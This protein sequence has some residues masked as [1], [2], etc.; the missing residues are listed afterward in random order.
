M[1]FFI[2][3]S[4][5]GLKRFESESKL[6]EEFLLRANKYQTLQ[7]LQ[8]DQQLYRK[9][10]LVEVSFRMRQGNNIRASLRQNNAIFT[11]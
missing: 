9:I 6:F 2:D 11:L 3:F 5:L 7:I 8:Q 1:F 10:I 4:T